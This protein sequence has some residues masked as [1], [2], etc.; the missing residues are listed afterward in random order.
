MSC[1]V[2][3]ISNPCRC[4]V[5][6]QP[7]GCSP[8]SPSGAIAPCSNVVPA[9]PTPYYN[10]ASPCPENHNTKIVIQQFYADIKIA[11][12]WNIPTCGGLAIVNVP[13]LKSVNI[14]SY[15][16]DNTYGYFE[17]TAFDGATGNLTVLNHCNDGNVSPG[18]TVPACTT[19]TITDPPI[20]V[21]SIGNTCVAID[22]T[23]PDVNDCIDITLTNENNL[24]ASDTIQIGS[25]FYFVE[26]VKPNNII[27][28]C[29]RGEGITPG[30]PVIAL[31]AVGD[32]Q[33][34]LT[35]ISA[36][37]C[38][39]DAITMG[40]LLACSGDGV[41]A[42]ITGQQTGYIPVLENLDGSVEFLPVVD[43]PFCHLLVADL[44]IVNGTA[45][46]VLNVDSHGEWVVG[47]ILQI[48]NQPSYRF[49]IT[50]FVDSTHVNVTATPV[51]GGSS[52]IPAN[53]RVCTI[54]CCEALE[55][56]IEALPCDDSLYNNVTALISFDS[57]TFTINNASSS[58][59]T[60]SSDT[61]LMN[62][63][64]CR[65]MNITG[66]V[67]AQIA[68]NSFFTNSD[69]FW[70]Q[71]TLQE[72]INGGAYSSIVS[73]RKSFFDFDDGSDYPND[74]TFTY[75]R[76]FTIAPLA[77]LNVKYRLLVAGSSGF[78]PSPNAALVAPSKYQVIASSITGSLIGIVI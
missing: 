13:G 14:G 7:L 42:P 27:T 39:A 16:W 35:I 76:H 61:T 29:N 49:E 74:I 33:Y 11:D 64:P 3:G 52:T 25:G 55:N 67:S 31:N 57:G 10:C 68:G 51:P 71:A 37:P 73:F 18:T 50:G 62:D 63:S 8:C 12:S 38:D 36:N 45:N 72:S 75:P 21:P 40:K 24:R 34:C 1:T 26:A 77:S 9:A 6:G 48:A 59:T 4:R 54:G 70:I 46:Y 56:E 5:S 43:I 41:A 22:F 17:I 78:P 58:H 47:D 28:I 15:I 19:F 23:A 2:C 30:T 69:P 66:T 32:Y 60:S 53:S 44:S 65:S 20:D